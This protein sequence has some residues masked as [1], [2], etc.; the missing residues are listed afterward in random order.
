MRQP[1]AK[2]EVRWA[3]HGAP[4][5]PVAGI[6]IAVPPTTPIPFGP[7]VW[8]PRLKQPCLTSYKPESGVAAEFSGAEAAP[9]D[10]GASGMEKSCR[11]FGGPLSAAGPPSSSGSAARSR[12]VW[13]RCR[14]VE[15]RAEVPAGPSR[16][17]VSSART[18]PTSVRAVNRVGDRRRR[19]DVIKPARRRVR[20]DRPANA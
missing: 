15:A 18:T 11:H 20:L 4:L 5:C 7:T 16:G 10:S 2:A 1:R 14:C 19:R 13:S 8:E 17:R 6:P 3:A 9:S 12:T